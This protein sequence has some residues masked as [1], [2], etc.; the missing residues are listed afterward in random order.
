MQ[1][2]QIVNNMKQVGSYIGNNSKYIKYFILLVLLIL[3]GTTYGITHN[4]ATTNWLFAVFAILLLACAGFIYVYFNIS[5]LYILIFILVCLSSLLFLINKIAGIVM[6]VCVGL[7]LLYLLYVA[8]IKN[9]NLNVLVNIF[10]SDIS[11]TN[12]LYSINKIANF[13]CNYFLKG[14]LVQLISKS[15]L[16]VFLMYLALVVYI[17]TKQPYQIVSD[18]KSIFLCIFLLI[19]FSLLSL[20]V[21]GVE[22]FVPFIMSF[23]KYLVLF[24]IVIGI[25]LAVLHVYK[26]VPIVANTVLFAINIAILV[27]IFAMIVKYIGAEAPGYISGPSTWSSLIFKIIIY[28]PCLFLNLVDFFR[29]ELKLAQQQWT[30]IIILIIEIVLI[31]LLFLLPKVFDVIINHNG[32]VILNKVLPLEVNSDPFDTVTLDSNNN[33]TNSLTPSLLDNAMNKKPN[34]E[35]GVS[36]WFYIHPEPKNTN[37]SYTTPGGV[38]IINFSTTTDANSGAP[39]ISFDASNNLLVINVDTA[40]ANSTPPVKIPAQLPAQ[41]PDVTSAPRTVPLQRWNHIFINFNNNGIMD[42]F[43]NNNLESSTPNIIPKLPSSLIVGSAS[44]IY[45]QVCNV[46]YYRNVLGTEGISWIYNAYKDLN[47]P[48]KPNF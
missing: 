30:Y 26:N 38:N 10:F 21:M 27:G 37:P 46:V 24:G 3:C 36:A 32:E 34:Y 47:P 1:S 12:P 6:S 8:Y 23:L 29:N 35:Y 5:I 28:I 7:L 41:P 43:L 25:I 17:Y 33:P 31:V 15:M 4:F 14:F 9:E 18:N 40:G 16:I 19:G 20:L 11:I 45:G 42:V 44:G 13:I 48:L 2:S 39:Q 22:A